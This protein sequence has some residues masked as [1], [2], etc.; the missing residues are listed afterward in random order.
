MTVKLKVAEAFRNDVGRGIVRVDSKVIEE[1]G[2]NSGEVVEVIGKKST[3]AIIWRGHPQ[4][5]GLDLIRMDGFTRYNCGASLGDT[6]TIKKAA[7]KEA[8]SIEFSPAEALRIS[9]N[10]NQYLKHRLMGRVFI[11][12]DRIVVGVL[13]SSMPLVVIMDKIFIPGCPLFSN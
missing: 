2:Q 13:G 8:A 12:G 10:F 7:P 9:G 4:D 3:P 11:N 6:I 5:E 1:L